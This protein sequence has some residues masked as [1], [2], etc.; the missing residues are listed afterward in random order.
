M[1]KK[2]RSQAD[3]IGKQFYGK[4]GES[5]SFRQ[6]MDESKV[7][8]QLRGARRKERDL[9]DD[10][11][12]DESELRGDPDITADMDT[13]EEENGDDELAMEIAALQGTTNQRE[14]KNDVPGLEAALAKCRQVGPTGKKLG[15]VE[16]L[17][18]TGTK[19]CQEIVTD[20]HDDLQ[21]EATFYAHTLEGVKA[22]FERLD[23][24]G[25]KYQRPDDYYAEMIKTDHH[26][27]KVKTKLLGEK[28]RID[29]KE[30][31][32]KQR[33][34]KKLGK[35][36]QAE[37]TQAKAKQKNSDLNAIKQWRKGA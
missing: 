10:E 29:E 23:A 9:S 6:A 30:E 16:R 32:R 20:V 27:E 22:S 17:V 35:Q 11:D 18:T 15:F 1:G 12:L 3:L 14:H 24:L 26:M 19:T 34:N 7:A 25:M 13:D 31:K 4:D 33:D 2:N 28:E 8:K 5:K 37:R 21:R 36:I